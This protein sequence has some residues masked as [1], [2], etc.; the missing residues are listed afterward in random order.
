[1]NE[2]AP[3]LIPAVAT[4]IVGWLGLKSR[5]ADP[6]QMMHDELKRMQERVKTL[7]DSSAEQ[8]DV[9]DDLR[10]KVGRLYDWLGELKDYVRHLEDK[11]REA[12]G[13]PHTRPKNID[14]IFKDT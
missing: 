8:W 13:K 6:S 7:E 11:L 4:I 1:M 5:K 9:I 3:Y 10:K 2:L 12:T 14:D